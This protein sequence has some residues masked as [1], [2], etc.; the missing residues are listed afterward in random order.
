M[1]KSSLEA[2]S[3]QDSYYLKAP[4][5][6]YKYA[7]EKD[8]V[9]GVNKFQ[10][11]TFHPFNKEPI[12][13]S[14]T[15]KNDVLTGMSFDFKKDEA[16]FNQLKTMVEKKYGKPMVKSDLKDEQCI[17]KN[18][19]NFSV[20]SGAETFKWAEKVT[21][22]AGEEVVTDFTNFVFASCPSRLDETLIKI[23]MLLFS[24]SKNKVEAPKPSAF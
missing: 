17:Y 18:G 6:D 12:E 9:E 16:L 4:L 21:N 24:I 22:E 15:F 23:N 14:F 7:E 2:L 20:K 13:S 11:S 19:A 10:G 8:K 5:V 1:S 3:A